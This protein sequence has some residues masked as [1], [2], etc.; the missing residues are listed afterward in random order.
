MLPIKDVI[1]TKVS[2]ERIIQTAAHDVPSC[3]TNYS[4]DAVKRAP[5]MLSSDFVRVKI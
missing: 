5:V 3:L 4:C 1:A 2:D